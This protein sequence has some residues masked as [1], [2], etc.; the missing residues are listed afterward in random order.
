MSIEKSL[1]EISI[2]LRTILGVLIETGGVV[3]FQ[4]KKKAPPKKKA[5]SKKKKEEE[6][7]PNEITDD[8]V[9]EL[10]DDPEDVLAEPEVTK[11]EIKAVL[12]SI[13]K[14]KDAKKKTALKTLFESMGAK[15]ISEV[16]KTKYQELY[17]AIKEI[18]NG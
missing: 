13:L 16:P 3:P 18:Q 11:D 4:E 9:E 2:T 12:G 5:P 15:G 6:P 14:E 7:D 1:E 8:D 17:E 10:D